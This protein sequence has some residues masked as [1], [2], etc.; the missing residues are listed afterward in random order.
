MPNWC[1]TYISFNGSR[2]DVENLHR[3]IK[4]CMSAPALPN[5]WNKDWLG[6][7]LVNSG[8]YSIEDIDNKP[9]PSCRGSITEVGDIM[10]GFGYEATFSV[11]T[12]T[13]W[14]PMM[15]VWTELI[16]YCNVEI[17]IIYTAIEEG[18]G[19]YYTND[20]CVVGKYTVFWDDDSE[21]E[22]DEKYATQLIGEILGYTNCN[23]IEMLIDMYESGNVSDDIWL[24]VHK[25][26]YVPLEELS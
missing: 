1:S 15:Q 20:P 2:N 5:S 12:E 9:H 25:Y 19:I 21:Y 7:V 11:Y 4:D 22:I 10:N 23:N 26:E 17:D 13:A 24:S 14:G 3:V 16:D 6:N 18:C 8:M